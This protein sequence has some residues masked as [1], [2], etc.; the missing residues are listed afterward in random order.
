MPFLKSIDN[1][2]VLQRILAIGTKSIDDLDLL[3]KVRLSNLIAFVG[4]LFGPVYSFMAFSVDSDKAFVTGIISSGIMSIPLIANANGYFKFSRY[5]ISIVFPLLILMSC[6]LL[7]SEMDIDLMLL[8]FAAF[9][10]VLF[11]KRS[12]YIPLILYSTAIW[13]ICILVLPMFETSI[14]LHVEYLSFI[15]KCLLFLSI[16]ILFFQFKEQVLIANSKLK[17]QIRLAERSEERF[18]KMVENIPNGAITILSPDYIVL[19]GA[20]S[21]VNEN[22]PLVERQLGMN[23]KDILGEEQFALRQPHYEVALSGQSSIFESEYMGETYIN[24]VSPIIVDG[25]VE[26]LIIASQKTTDIKRAQKELDKQKQLTQNIY[27]NA[28][29]LISVLSQDGTYVTVNRRYEDHFGVPTS[30]IIGQHYS[31]LLQNNVTEFDIIGENIKKTLR[32]GRLS[33][34]YELKSPITGEVMHLFTIYTRIRLENEDMVM[35]MAMNISAQKKAEQKL[36]DSYRQLNERNNI[37]YDSINYAKR[38]QQSVLD[39]SQGFINRTGDMFVYF[40]PKDVLSGDFF[41]AADINGKRLIIAAD[42]TG[43]GVPGAMLTLIGTDFL[44]EIIYSYQI[45]KP[46]IILQELDRK[47]T[48]MLTLGTDE[49]IQD[50]IDLSIILLDTEKQQI[51][52]A[53][54]KS[55]VF[56]VK[57]NGEIDKYSGDR[58]SIGGHKHM[59]RKAFTSSLITYEDGD[60]LYMGSDGYGD[61]FGGLYGKKYGKKRLRQ[62]FSEIHSADITAQRKHVEDTFL[63][64]KKGRDQ[65]DDVLM[66]GIRL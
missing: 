41:W 12:R 63:D 30:E 38:I 7:G 25:E 16:I 60:M 19:D 49:R 3:R 17:D 65:L 26:S 52:I 45:H 35:L 39:T 40:N 59:N 24:S 57:S 5:W 31:T 61:Q 28:P 11:D 21:D 9:P 1:V 55:P 20:G 66:I 2:P 42:A 22:R 56:H 37:I 23:I 54:A 51:E 46:D 36:Q 15:N 18:R 10:L 6:S 44:N 62:L 14:P 27:D 50:G 29:M 4:L 48:Q 13:L 47:F 64:W 43:H 34:T 8:A 33:Y 32:D 58:Y 53:A